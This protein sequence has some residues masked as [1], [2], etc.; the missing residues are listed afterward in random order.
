[1]STAMHSIRSVVRHSLSRLGIEVQ[2]LPLRATDIAAC[3]P[4]E[5]TLEAASKAGL[6]IGDYIDVVANGKVGAT[7]ATFEGMRQLGV[8]DEKIERV[9]EIGPGTG[10]YMEK[11]LQSCSADHY[12]FYEPDLAWAHYLEKRYGTTRQP[13]TGLNLNVTETAS[14]DLAQ[15]L[16]VFSAVDLITTFRYWPEMV[17]V[18]RPGG[19]VVFDVVTESCLDPDTVDRW[20]GCGLRPGNYPGAVPRATVLNYFSARGFSTTGT[21]Q[22]PMGPGTTEVF[23]FRKQ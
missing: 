12:E 14:I 18:T 15:A 20:T 2:P 21:F 22:I 17:R 23:V 5:L 8:F 4:F 9:V 7:Q 10:R 16:K 11:T 1:M 19:W 6:S 13:A 3:I